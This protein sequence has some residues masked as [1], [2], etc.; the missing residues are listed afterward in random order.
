VDV[1]VGVGVGVCMWVVD[2]GVC[3]STGEVWM[4]VWVSGC[5]GGGVCGCRCGC[6]CGGRVSAPNFVKKRCVLVS[7]DTL[8]GWLVKAII[9]QSV[10]ASL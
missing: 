10:L 7:S 9:C 3:V 5:G 4:Q 6:R 2:V 1:G 8:G